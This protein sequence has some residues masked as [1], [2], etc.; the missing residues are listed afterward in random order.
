MA[1]GMNQ[2]E[3]IGGEMEMSEA[4]RRQMENENYRQRQAAERG[5]I[6]MDA[7]Q[8]FADAQLGNAQLAGKG[9]ADVQREQMQRDRENEVSYNQQANLKRFNELNAIRI[10]AQ[11]QEAEQ[12]RMRNA[13]LASAV[14]FTHA[15]GGYLPK[16]LLPSFSE[17]LGVP[18]AGGNLDKDGNMFF[19]TMSPDGR[20][21]QPIAMVDRTH[22]AAALQEAGLD[23]D[24]YKRLYGMEAEKLTPTQ[25]ESFGLRNPNAPIKTGGVAGKNVARLFGR[26]GPT[27]S[28]VSMFSTAGGG[29]SATFH[30]DGT[31]EDTGYADDKKEGKWSVLRSDQDGQVYENSKTGETVTVPKGKNLRDVL[32]GKSDFNDNWHVQQARINAD[33]RVQAAQI[34]A[35]AKKGTT[36]MIVDGKVA[37]ADRSNATALKKAQMTIE[38]YAAKNESQETIA[39]INS[40]AKIDV[41]KIVSDGRIDVTKLQ[42]ETKTNIAKIETDAKKDMSDD[43]LDALMYKTNLE[44]DAKI[45]AVEA[46]V[47]NAEEKNAALEHIASEKNSALL[48]IEKVRG[49]YKERI[50]KQ[51]ETGRMARA[52]MQ[53]AQAWGKLA[54]E[55][56]KIDNDFAVKMQEADT[57][58]KRVDLLE[59][60]IENDY[61]LGLKRAET[62]E[63]KAKVEAE[64][65]DR[66][67]SVAEG[68]YDINWFKASAAAEI[69]QQKVTNQKE[70]AEMNNRTKLLVAGL[71]DRSAKGVKGAASD[72][73]RIQEIQKVLAEGGLTRENRDKLKDEMNEIAERHGIEESSQATE[74]K[75]DNRPTPEEARK[76]LLATGKYKVVDGKLV[77]K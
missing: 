25:L 53:D 22:Q 48:A 59:Q 16:S 70:I 64:Y 73:K 54:N 61:E 45:A 38:S 65:K 44:Y 60:K 20:Q 56:Q 28:T 57:H 34:A 24:L 42:G 10:N 39:R 49:D 32:G 18:L 27:R 47:T 19:Y 33:A 75:E 35:D 30:P 15:N 72:M 26:T 17:S 55:M 71:G 9:W 74:Q 63:E 7:D 50:E 6:Q 23:P 3:N 43:K 76:K 67:A 14:S 68:N 11:K 2:F 69:G 31:V 5:R 21:L 52:T 37:V 58:G 12:A 4:Q 41:A 40:Q 29:R 62:A 36:K 77:R 13:D 8:Q 66:M 46:S 51:R 1:F